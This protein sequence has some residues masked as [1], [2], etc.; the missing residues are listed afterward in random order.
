MKSYAK[1]SISRRKFLA[2]SALVGFAFHFVPSRL[3][4]ADAPSNKLNIAVLGGII[5]N[6]TYEIRVVASYKSADSQNANAQKA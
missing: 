1:K 2:N 6:T 3:L 5:R 4:G